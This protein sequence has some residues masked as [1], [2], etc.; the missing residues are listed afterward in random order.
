MR[1]EE[2]REETIVTRRISLAS[3]F[4]TGYKPDVLAN[5]IDDMIA[6]FVFD[7]QLPWCLE[8]VITEEGRAGKAGEKL[9]AVRSGQHVTEPNILRPP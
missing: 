4:K 3:L 9:G 2:D 1:S 7:F 6:C 5:W 8:V